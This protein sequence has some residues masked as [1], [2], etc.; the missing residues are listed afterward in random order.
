MEVESRFA[1]LP[2]VEAAGV[3]REYQSAAWVQWV[4]G[5]FEVVACGVRGARGQTYLF[6][7]ML[8]STA[9]P[10]SSGAAALAF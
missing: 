4:A 9:P 6:S 3:S 5:W 8:T 10:R 7:K 2:G 1:F